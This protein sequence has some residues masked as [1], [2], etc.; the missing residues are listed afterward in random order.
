MV[1]HKMKILNIGDLNDNVYVLSKFTKAEIHQINFPRKQVDLVT[2]SEKGIEFFDSLLISKQVHRINQ[3][4]HKFDLCL[5]LSWAGARVAY[6]AGLNYIIYFVGDDIRNPPF[7][8]NKNPQI[9]LHVKTPYNYNFIE[10]IFYKKILN[11]AIACVTASQELF[12]EL[13]KY[14]DQ[15]IECIELAI[16]TTMFNENT[17]PLNKPKK[18]FTFFCPQRI[19]IEK[20][21]DILW[22]ALRL[23][24]SDFEILQSQWFIETST[25]SEFENIHDP[26]NKKL[27]ED[28]PSQIKF[29]PLIKREE[30]PRWFMWADGIIGQLSIGYHGATEMEAAFCKKPVVHYSDPQIKYTVNGEKITAPFLPHSKNPKEVARIIDKVVTSQEFRKKLAEE[31]NKFVKDIGDSKFIASKWDKIFEKMYQ[32]HGTINRKDNFSIN[33]LNIFALLAEKFVYSKTMKKE[34]LK[35]GGKKNI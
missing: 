31:E 3:I 17:Q 35:H 12:N 1:N 16:D 5:V 24:K 20:G 34:I 13:K 30:V 28:V 22:D 7:A 2:I 14:R 6:L 25:I 18:K 32:K 29:V 19:G 27:L 33:S 21:Y 9:F 10:K 11:S 8:K 4:K 23:C 26:F 15:N